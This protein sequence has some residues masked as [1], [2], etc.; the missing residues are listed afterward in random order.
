MPKVLVVDDSLSVRVAG[1][2]AA[3]GGPSGSGP[4]GPRT[5]NRA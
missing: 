2:G 1:R 3:L 5:V 4:R